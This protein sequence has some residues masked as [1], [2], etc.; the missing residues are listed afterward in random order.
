MC[1]LKLIR[2]N[3]GVQTFFV[4]LRIGNSIFGVVRVFVNIENYIA[5]IGFSYYVVE[6]LIGKCTFL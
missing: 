4:H 5:F 3:V 1:I 6:Q 2:C